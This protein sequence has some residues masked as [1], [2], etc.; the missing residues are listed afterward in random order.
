MKQVLGILDLPQMPR[1]QEPDE[2]EPARGRCS[3]CLEAIV[4]QVDYKKKRERL[5]KYIR[6]KV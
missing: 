6:V 3:K 1:R 5:N 2:N 4:G